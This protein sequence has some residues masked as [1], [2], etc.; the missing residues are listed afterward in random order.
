MPLFFFLILSF[1]VA[2]QA[3]FFFLAIKSVRSSIA[4][5][6]GNRYTVTKIPYNFIHD[7]CFMWAAVV[8]FLMLIYGVSFV[9]GFE[10]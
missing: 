5:Y 1:D 4:F 3:S 9:K 10:C 2:Y 7:F 8:Y 6:L